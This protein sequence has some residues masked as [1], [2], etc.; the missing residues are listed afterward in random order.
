MIEKVIDNAEIAKMIDDAFYFVS[1]KKI[2]PASRKCLIEHLEALNLSEP[3][4]RNW[5]ID[6]SV[7]SNEPNC[8]DALFNTYEAFNEYLEMIRK[9]TNFWRTLI[10]V[11][12]NPYYLEQEFGF[13]NAI[14]EYHN[15]TH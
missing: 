10:S 2:P 12:R 13:N 14:R 4:E 8:P 5:L 9:N 11:E 1:I 3:I 6:A 15:A 7:S